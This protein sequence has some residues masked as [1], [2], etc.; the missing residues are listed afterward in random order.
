MRDRLPWLGPAL[1][2]LAFLGLAAAGYVVAVRGWGRRLRTSETS[3]PKRER[4]AAR[5]AAA[6]RAKLS[7]SSAT[8]SEQKE[9]PKLPEA[10]AMRLI[11]ATAAGISA[12]WWAYPYR[13]TLSAARL[14]KGEQQAR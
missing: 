10:D 2:A 5:R 14:D 13:E 9:L 1:G 3:L 7:P 4:E 12:A 6:S 11:A 8:D